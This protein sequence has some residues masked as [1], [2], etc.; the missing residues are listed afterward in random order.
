MKMKNLILVL[1][2]AF[3]GALIALFSYDYFKIAPEMASFDSA[4]SPFIQAVNYTSREEPFNFTSASSV[5]TPAVVHVNTRYSHTNT[6]GQEF[7][8][9]DLFEYF[10]GQPKQNNPRE[11]KASG[12][13]VIISNDGYIVT[14]NHVVEN[15]STIEVTLSNNK[16]YKATLVGTD[17]DTDLALLKIDAKDLPYLNFA[18]S[19]EVLVG[20]W[21][22]AVGNP[23]NLASTVTAGIVSAKGR[24]IHLLENLQGTSNT[25]IESFIQTDAAINPGNSGGALVNLRGEVIGINTAIATPTG[26]YAGYAFAVPAN[27]A[28]KVVTDLKEFGAVQRAFIGVNIISVDN[29][30][31][32]S[33]GLKEVRGV[34][35]QNVMEGGAADQAGL[36]NEDVILSINDVKVNDVAALQEKIAS[37]RPGNVIKVSFLRKNV[38][39]YATLTLKNKFNNQELLTADADSNTTSRR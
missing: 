5:A 37:F 24:N 21:V 33:L 27:I 34:Y 28:S 9:N 15:S 3:L 7:Y 26:T 17:K 30:I 18:N 13:G 2:S 16:M 1:F 11:S 19:D 4:A 39:Q 8:G 31:A 23:F 14:N 12:S 25:A 29:D 35:L 32:K 6:Y 36:Q 20:E 38:L 22:L 10:F